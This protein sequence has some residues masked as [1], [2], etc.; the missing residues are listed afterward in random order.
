MSFQ[1][2]YKDLETRLRQSKPKTEPL[3]P[4][5]KRQMRQELMEQMTMKE[6]PFTFRKLSM[7]LGG[8]IILIGIPVFFWLAQMSV[9]T[10]VNPG[11]GGLWAVCSSLGRGGRVARQRSAKP[12]TAVR[13]R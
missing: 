7:A 4:A 11:A 13:I 9:G 3:P 12:S 1:D 8:L 5:L 2:D 6:N 10:A